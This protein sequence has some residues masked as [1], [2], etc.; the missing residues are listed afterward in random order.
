MYWESG[1]RLSEPFSDGMITLLKG[2]ELTL[3]QDAFLQIVHGRMKAQLL[4]TPLSEISDEHAIELVT[5][6]HWQRTIENPVVKILNG[7]ISIGN[8]SGGVSMF[9]HSCTYVEWNYL[10]HKQYAVPLLFGLN[11]WA[12]GKDAIELG[13]AVAK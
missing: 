11:H 3:Q 2:Q 12:N 5:R 9:W 7:G 8:K 4:L 13:I 1:I 10:K 6:A